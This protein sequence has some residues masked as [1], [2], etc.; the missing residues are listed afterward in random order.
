M[1]Y[2]LSGQP[3]VRCPHQAVAT[4]NREFPAYLDEM[5]RWGDALLAWE[6]AAARFEMPLKNIECR[7]DHDPGFFSAI[8]M[9]RGTSDHRRAARLGPGST[10]CLFRGE[11]QLL[12]SAAAS[13]AVVAVCRQERAQVGHK[14]AR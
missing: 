1:N 8:E 13:L 2:V 11:P 5:D 10:G 7:E 9:D 14:R 4:V 3:K 6:T 12:P